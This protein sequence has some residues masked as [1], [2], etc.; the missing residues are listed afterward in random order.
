MRGSGQTAAHGVKKSSDRSC[1]GRDHLLGNSLNEEGPL[2]R[3]KTIVR[4]PYKENSIA[5]PYLEN[6]TS[7]LGS[8]RVRS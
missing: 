7:A 2:I 4:Y 1:H 8:F 6:Y 3:S 5:D